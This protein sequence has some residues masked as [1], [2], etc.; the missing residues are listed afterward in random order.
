MKNIIETISRLWWIKVRG[1][2]TN[3]RSEK[4]IQAL[5]E[6]LVEDLE[7]ED[8]VVGYV[9]EAIKGE[10]KEPEEEKEEPKEKEDETPDEEK[11]GDK[12]VAIK[13][14]KYGSLTQLEKD[15]LKE[16]SI[17]EKRQPGEVWKT[18]SGWAG[19]KPGEKSAQYGMKSKDTAQTYVSG[20][21]IDDAESDAEPSDEFKKDTGQGEDDKKTPKV[22][23]DAE[24]NKVLQKTAE[25]FIDNDANK[26]SGA[27]R[28]SLSKEDVKDYKEYLTLSPEERTK[29]LDDISNKQ[30]QKIGKVKEFDIDTTVNLL[31][32]QLGSKEFG[33]LKASIKGKGGPPKEYLKGKAENPNPPP[34]E[35]AKS[36]LRFRNVIRHYLETG[37]VSPITGKV[38]PFHDSQLDHI[39]SLDNGGKDGPENWMWMESRM[40]QF[41]GKL[42]DTEVEARLIEQGLQTANELEV[43][44][45]EKDLKNWNDAVEVAY[46]EVNLKKGDIQNLSVEKIKN[47]N[48]DQLNNLIK[49]YNESVG[50]ESSPDAVNRYGQNTTKVPGIENP[51]PVSRGGYLKPDKDNPK[52][53]GARVNDKGEIS[54]PDP[55]LK[56]I[57]DGE[58][59]YDK[60]RQSGGRALGREQLEQTIVGKLGDKLPN[61]IT[62]NKIDTAFED[63]QKEKAKRKADIDRLNKIIKDNPKSAKNS[64]K[65]VDSDYKNTDIPKKIKDA[66]GSGS[67]KRP[68]NKEAYDNAVKEKNDWMLDRWKKQEE[69]NKLQD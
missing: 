41:K 33:K 68:E 64:K 46:W 48:K 43:G 4:S 13:N 42:T 38:V 50:G 58:K 40:N 16:Q 39:T 44:M 66:I 24:R 37:G 36:E 8:F 35:I 10:P 52:T 65:E 5:E 20:K 7:F 51:I 45:K 14:I 31:K 61:T 57:E 30:E 12:D 55:P 18:K 25:L 34:A 26:V 67:R 11:D 32:E 47:M 63:I 23:S 27:G 6:V 62:E 53:W 69:E 1:E 3:P 19:L 49:G 29:K 59:L 15:K 2:L 22:K 60:D 56:N 9:I 54:Y 28:Y 21:E 17:T